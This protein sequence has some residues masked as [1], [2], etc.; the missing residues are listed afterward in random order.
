MSRIRTIQPDFYKDDAL[1]D[2]SIYARFIF[3]GLWCLADKRGRIEDRP[4]RIKVEL[5]PYDAPEI[6]PLIDELADAGFLF[7]YVVE[8]KNYIQ[9]K[10]FE[11]HQRPHHTEKES[12]IPEFNGGITVTPPSAPRKAPDGREG[13]GRERKGIG[14]NAGAFDATR[15][16]EFWAMFPNKRDKQKAQEAFKRLNPD[17][18][19]FKKMMD[20]LKAEISYREK[21]DRSGE[22]VPCWKYGQ[23]WING[24]RWEDE[25]TPP[26]TATVNYLEG[27]RNA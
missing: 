23:G 24:K 8:D 16:D 1:A 22:F 10:G 3:P 6:A 5:L 2:L 13:K 18:R 25:L 12:E 27:V 14:A 20:G 4:R 9:I 21:M 15:F 26:A 19:L 11:K 17:D 7:R